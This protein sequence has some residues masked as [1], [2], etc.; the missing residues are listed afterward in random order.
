MTTPFIGTEAVGAGDVTPY[1]LRSRHS[2][3]YPGVYLPRGT[4]ISAAMRAEAGWLW[5]RRRGIV[6]GRSAAALH[7]AKWVKDMLPAELIHDNRHPPRGIR[8]WAD[9]I[10]EDEIV[11]VG[12]VR[13]TSVAR[14]LLDIGCRR[15]L[16]GAVPEMDALVRATRADLV[17]AHL[18]AD[19]YRGRRGIRRARTALGLVDGGAESPR[20]TWLRLLLITAGLPRPRTQIRVRD[21]YGQIVARLDMGWPELKIGVEYDGDQHWTDRRQLSRDIRRTEDL[22]EL[23]WIIVRVTADATEASI[24][25]WVEAAFM[26]RM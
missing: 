9:T 8:I 26:R 6:A 12:G 17:A 14:T 1:A 16:R 23:G 24:L 5:S 10:D 4:P 2:A 15:P 13:I 22:R 20:E 3:I 18:L 11:V 7:G 25:G 21:E 19:R